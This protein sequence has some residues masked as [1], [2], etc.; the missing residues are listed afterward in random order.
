MASVV[1]I[2]NRALQKVGAKRITS[3]TEDSKNARACNVAYGPLR[4]AE[5]RAHFWSCAIKRAQLAADATAPDW[6]KSNAFQL[7]SDWLRM[8]TPYPESNTFD[9]DWEIEG[10]KIYT[11]QDAPLQIRYIA[12]ISDPNIM[13]ALLREAISSRMAYELCEELTDSNQKKEG[14]LGAYKLNIMEARKV[15]AIEK[16]AATQPEDSWVT[17]RETGRDNTHSSW[18]WGI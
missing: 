14:L 6:G 4:L 11:N 8:A 13:D 9:N 16:I 10:L 18:W 12:D 1:E 15:N 5:L 3:I 17:A 7:P 2:C